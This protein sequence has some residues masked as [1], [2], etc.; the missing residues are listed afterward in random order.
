RSR[1]NRL[2]LSW[3]SESVFPLNPNPSPRQTKNGVLRTTRRSKY[4]FNPTPTTLA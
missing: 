3:F 1:P 2:S 4:V